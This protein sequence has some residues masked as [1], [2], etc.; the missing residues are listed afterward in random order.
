MTT[1]ITPARP[2]WGDQKWPNPEVMERPR[3]R[4]F[5]AEYRLAILREADACTKKGQLGALL[6]R[7]GLY[8]S[9]LT[10]WRKQRDRGGLAGL[11]QPRGRRPKHTEAE[12]E[13]ARLRRDNARLTKELDAAR[14]VIDVQKNVSALLGIALESAELRS[15][16]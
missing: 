2:T 14:L 4:T 5:T 11:G 9:H 16:Q 8:S 12:R 1:E 3:R 10:D 15:E 6:R 13:I 7:E